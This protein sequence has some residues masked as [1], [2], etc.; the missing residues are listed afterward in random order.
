MRREQYSAELS[1]ALASLAE[2]ITPASRAKLAGLL[3]HDI[4]R[5]RRAFGPSLKDEDSGY[6]DAAAVTVRRELADIAADEAGQA[7]RAP[8]VL[9]RFDQ[10]YGTER[11]A[12]FAALLYHCAWLTAAS[13]DGVDSDEERVLHEL[14]AELGRPASERSRAALQEDASAPNELDRNEVGEDLDAALNELQSLIGLDEVKSQV[15]TLVNFLKVQAE[16]KRRGLGETS[17]S[18]HCVFMGPPGTGK[19]T[20]ARILS[21]IFHHSGFLEKGHLVETDRAGL[22]GQYIG[23]T[24]KK[25]EERVQEALGGVLFIDEAYAL[26]VEDGGRD[27]GQEAIDILIKRMED[28]REE[29]VLIAA[30]YPDEMQRFVQSNPGLESRINRYIRF[31][32]YKPDAL[33]SIFR[34]FCEKAAYRLEDAAAD[35]LR[36]VFAEEYANRGRTFGNG[37]LARNLFEKI[38]ERQANRLAQHVHS[39]SDDDLVLITVA[40]VVPGTT[41]EPEGGPEPATVE[42]GPVDQGPADPRTAETPEWLKRRRRP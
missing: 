15:F 21:R 19:T 35:R 32:H 37:R 36:R 14:W 26:K 18:L 9:R 24:A 11:S 4:E 34:L 8:S 29:F 1:V 25:T 10:R 16:R 22:V 7:C 17:T 6:L 40:D 2:E 38:I 23:H 42:E 41:P 33:L 27:F 39:L 31:D 20:V 5:M 13:R 12:A 30:G 28:L 3:L